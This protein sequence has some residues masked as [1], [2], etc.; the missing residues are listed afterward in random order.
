MLTLSPEHAVDPVPAMRREVLLRIE[1]EKLRAT[2][3]EARK[4]QRI[5][6]PTRMTPQDKEQNASMRSRHQRIEAF[7]FPPPLVPVV[8][9]VVKLSNEKFVRLARLAFRCT[10]FF[11][12][13]AQQDQFPAH[14]RHRIDRVLRRKHEHGG[15]DSGSI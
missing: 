15:A 9:D 11:Q 1:L 12:L 2:E 6:V 5:L 4:T 14:G 13:D 8:D 3:C 7:C 10:Q